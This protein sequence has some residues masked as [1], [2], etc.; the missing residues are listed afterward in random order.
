MT[1]KYRSSQYEPLTDIVD[2]N[3]TR[4]FTLTR[5]WKGR[6]TMI[7]V[8][9]ARFQLDWSKKEVCRPFVCR[10]YICSG[11][12]VCVMLLLWPSI[13]TIWAQVTDDICESL[14]LYVHIVNMHMLFLCFRPFVR[15]HV[16][17]VYKY[18]SCKY[19]RVYNQSCNCLFTRHEKAN[20]WVR[21]C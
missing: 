10:P 2:T 13:S 7:H 17:R 12:W 15:Q 4:M 5:M 19:N 3:G 14:Y 16:L 11:T 6:V 1:G 20:C 18:L 9:C 8:P 21:A